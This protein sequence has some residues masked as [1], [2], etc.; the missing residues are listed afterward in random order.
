MSTFPRSTVRETVRLSGR[1]LHTGVPVN[2]LI[3][4][5]QD[6]IAFRLGETRVLARP[7]N[8]TDTARSTKLGEIGTIE[9]L[10]SAF[11]G[12]EITD[13]E[14]EVDAP[15][16]PG[17]DGSAGPFVDALLAVGT[18]KF[19]DQDVHPPFTRL[20]LQEENGL[21]MAVGKGEGHWRYVYDLGERWPGAQSFESEDVNR[22]YVAEIARARTFALSEELPMIQKYGLGQGLDETSAVVIGTSGYENE[23]RFADEPARH[24]LLDLIGDLYLAGVPLRALNVVGERTGHRANVKVAAMLLKAVSGP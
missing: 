15:E 8:V 3:H 10:M 4:P 1:G 20:F 14:V 21:K 18:E 16:I 7:E 24:K 6:G 5:G 9:H 22:D 23:V 2:L 13:A 11:A 19:A 17:V 12:L